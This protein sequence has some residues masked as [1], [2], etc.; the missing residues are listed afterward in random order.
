MT[1]AGQDED[2]DRRW[3]RMVG[4][5]RADLAELTERFLARLAGGG[6]YDDQPVSEDDLRATAGESLTLL[7]DQLARPDGRV[8]L[9]EL[10]DRLGRR[11][12]QQGVDLD[13][14][15]RAV[16]LDFPVIW[17]ALL[18]RAGEADTPVLA[19][20]ADRLWAVVDAY[21]RQVHFAFLAEQSLLAE[22]H[23]DE[24]RQLLDLL[25][26]PG[27]LPAHQIARL[28][29]G[30]RVGADDTF[31]VGVA[32][33]D[34]AAALRGRAARLDGGL[35]RVFLRD[36]EFGVVAFWPARRDDADGDRL[37][38]R[39]TTGIGCVVT[40]DVTGL[41]A[42]PVVAASTYR[43]AQVLP[44]ESHVRAGP[45]EMWPLVARR[46]LDEHGGLPAR[47][48][49][50]LD[51]APPEERELLVR[52]V[53]AFLDSGSVSGVAA[54]LY[55][56]RNTVLNR[57]RRFTRLTGLDPARPR[58]AALALVVLDTLGDRP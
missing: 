24:Q 21:A 37:L 53:L 32:L 57:L 55:C 5:V 12:A 19:R 3:T 33:A 27:P 47:L 16:R 36:V 39:L 26:A 44:P 41:G 25:F 50:R 18:E 40:P 7:L 31:T 4:A 13:Q 30:L 15:V 28:A 11:R 43:M 10:P 22:Q 17:S 1:A 51:P 52:T 48:R 58:D 54:A 20:K 38:D 29:A 35:T 6:H 34:H 45:L 49:E 56:H 8:D 9:G 23:R 42:V 14:L 46:A 2:Q